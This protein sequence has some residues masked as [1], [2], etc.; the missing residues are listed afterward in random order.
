MDYDFTANVEKD[1]D[2]IAEGELQWN[3]VIEKFYGPF[4]KLVDT[5]MH[6]GQYSHVSRD[7]GTAP[8][9]EPLIAKYG[10]YGAYVQKGDGD[11]KKFASLGKGQLIETITPEEALKLF[12]L[13][14]CVGEFEGKEIKVT[15]GKF[16]PY[17]RWDNANFSLPKGKDPLKV[18][19]EEC[20]AI[21][22]AGKEGTGVNAVIA[23]FQGGNL[24][25][26][27]GRYGPYI[28]YSGSNYKIPKGTDAASLTEADALKIVE[29]SQPTSATKKFRKTYKK[30]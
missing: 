27:N 4:H 26:I 30:K 28:K 19:L 10:Q 24:S 29:E 20:V 12:E 6:D 9:G 11:N 14:R 8:D 15:K 13:P 5:N 25:I 2:H 18:T 3:K 1:F 21:I 17:F 16:G 22:Q 23:E 7:L